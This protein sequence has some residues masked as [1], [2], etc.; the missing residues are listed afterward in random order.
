MSASRD[1]EIGHTCDVSVKSQL[2][3]AV[4]ENDRTRLRELIL[5]NHC[6]PRF[7]RN[8][9]KE[10]LLHI[11][12]KLG[13]LDIIRSLVEVYQLCPFQVDGFSLTPCHLA[14]QFHHLHVLGYFFKL[15]G[16]T[17]IRDFQPI[18]LATIFKLPDDFRLHLL[19]EATSSHSVVMTRFVYTCL[20]VKSN[21]IGKMNLYYDSFNMLMKIIAPELSFQHKDSY[22]KFAAFY[23]RDNLNMLKLFL[24]E[25]VKVSSMSRPMESS[26]CGLFLEAACRLNNSEIV[27]YLTKRKGLC[28]NQELP[29]QLI[30]DCALQPCIH[31]NCGE[32]PYLPMHTALLS[33]NITF[34]ESIVLTSTNFIQDVASHLTTDHGTLL[35]SACVS[36]KLDL[37]KIVTQKFKGDIN[38]QNK[39][40]NTPL[41]VAC[42]WGWLEIVQFLVEI[43][44]NVNISN[45]CG[46]S[47]LT[48]AIKHSRLEIFK[49]LFS[50]NNVSIDVTTTDTNESTLHLACCCHHSEFAVALLNDP[51]YTISLDAVDKFGDTPLFNACRL[52]NMKVVQKLVAKPGCTRLMVNDITKETPAHIAC[53]N[54]RLD[55]LKVLLTVGLSEPLKNSHLNF[56]GESL[57]HIA[58]YNDAQE[59]IDFL[60]ENQIITRVSDASNVSPIHIA[61]KRGN[62]ETVKKL[63]KSGICKTTD[64]DMN[65]NTILHYIC[66]R[67]Q[68]DPEMIEML[69]KEMEAN[70]MVE[71]KNA[72]GYNPLHLIFENGGGQIFHCLSNCLSLERINNALHSVDKENN[73]PLHVAFRQQRSLTLRYLLDNPQFADGIS[74]AICTQNTRKSSPLHCPC[75]TE[76]IQ[77][78]FESSH[79][80]YECISRAVAL[81]DE[82][83]NNIFHHLFNKVV[84]NPSLLEV[85]SSTFKRFLKQF[86]LTDVVSVLCM[87][88]TKNDYDFTFTP[89]QLLI[90]RNLSQR[91]CEE[92]SV[93]EILLCLVDSPLT[94]ESMRDICSI[95]F[96]EGK[97]LVHFAL[98]HGFF[99][100]VKVLVEHKLCDPE[101]ADIFGRTPL[102]CA[103]NTDINTNQDIAC[104][105]CR[106]GCS[107]HT[108]DK[109]G[110]S[111]VVLC[112][113]RGYYSVSLLRRLLSEGYCHP[114]ETV[115][116]VECDNQI[117]RYCHIMQP[118][119]YHQ[120]IIELPLLHSMLYSRSIH[121]FFLPYIA[122]HE[123]TPNLCDSFGNTIFH[124]ESSYSLF[125]Y[126]VVDL[127]NHDLNKQNKEGN[128]PLHIACATGQQN[129]GKKLIESDKCG[130]SL[131]LRNRYGHTPVYY[132]SDRELINVLVMNGA[133]P[134]DVADS[135][136]VKHLTDM[137][138]AV[139]DKHPLNLTVT[140]L[141][142][143]NSLAGK[144][145]LLKSLT[146]ACNSDQLNQ[147]SVGQLDEK[148]ERTA[149][150]EMSEYVVNIKE[151]SQRVLFYDFAG[152]PEFH[153]THS[154]LLQNRLSSLESSRDSPLLFVIVIDITAPDKLKQ[155]IYW[156]KF[157][158][159]CQLSCNTGRKPEILIIGSHVDKYSGSDDMHKKLKHSLC[160][161]IEK[162]SDSIDLVENPIFLNCCK[163]EENEL[164]K[165]Q[166]ML[167]MSTKKLE[168][169]A[170]L[171][172]RCHLIFSY[173]YDHFPDK[174]V[175]FSEFQGKLRKRKP[176]GNIDFHFTTTTLQDL[177]TRLHQMQHIL[178]IG[179]TIESC[180]FWI[181]TAKAQNLMFH[182][183]QGLLFSGEDFDMRPSI[184]SNVGVISSTEIKAMFPDF[185]CKMLQQFLVYSEFC[186]KIDD[187]TVLQLIDC[188]ASNSVDSKEEQKMN[189]SSHV[190]NIPDEVSVVTETCD[191][192]DYFFFPG[193]VKETREKTKL[194]WKVDDKYSFC[195]GWSLECTQDEFFNALFLQVLLLRLTFQFAATS[196]PD[197]I[198]H[199]RCVI[200]KNGVFWS[201]PGV[202]MLVE[203]TNQN[204]SVIVLVRC[205]KDTEL[206]AIKLR[207]AVL[208]E[209]FKVKAKHS[210]ATKVI[211]FVIYNPSLD[212]NG[213]L[214]E[215]VKKVAMNEIA[216]SITNCVKYVQDNS[217]QHH[218]INKDLLCFEPYTGI[219]N[220]TLTSLFDPDETGKNVPDNILSSLFN[221]PESDDQAKLT[222]QFKKL[223]KN[224]SKPIS[225][226]HLRNLFD[227][228]SIFHGRDPKV[229][230]V[231]I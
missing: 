159:N 9:K 134:K 64:T 186:K 150:I 174:P 69:S 102:H 29:P 128:T 212:E 173:L 142:L 61:C 81:Q 133:D 216:A 58:C 162:M 124:L 10:T 37:V 193:L 80:S 26:V 145:T 169:L 206:E 67:Q 217:F 104:F 103:C 68:I 76:Y 147:P 39:H 27:N 176:G 12:S 190:P 88:N 201:V 117:Q 83:G 202:E 146:N 19:R 229:S 225:Y 5:S 203:V 132:T 20:C 184:K 43:G 113:Q 120:S 40:G 208:K 32:L 89:L 3:S 66:H 77:L 34:V 127:R 59:T 86:R 35:H 91:R 170:D 107:A 92:S 182:E 60:I 179:P 148:C 211:E 194:N 199:R 99:K 87:R 200:W 73:T 65:G 28:P 122:E 153:S 42:E 158:Q 219:D 143:G 97:T 70:E 53:R 25:L 100:T 189:Q 96:Y 54:D 231:H 75:R 183:V 121:N 4:E 93:I 166:M 85:V 98:E 22:L 195:S 192:I 94:A 222:E 226:E 160:Q 197:S 84:E 224:L 220:N 109:N 125:Q 188:E 111:P 141:V 213:S 181:L 204:Q 154:I 49:S 116:T 137:F 23:C 223:I 30:E 112:L 138:K 33:G 151:R 2:F 152:H 1:S 123:N 196:L 156:V 110:K 47:P 11:A 44:C 8:E 48:L 164:Q 45:N 50:N 105:L 118:S 131:S 18:H 72:S 215:P 139:K 57:L 114:M 17:Y 149:G 24:D 175:K 106:N 136:R 155:L 178:L 41:H 172:N 21:G 161:T 157:I 144:T 218:C 31:Y 214:T 140:A 185:E 221:K 210:P 165:V 187:E 163:P 126:K 115:Q 191:S 108:L 46:H 63:L 101:T 230:T 119:E 52:G 228:Y 7:V 177:I 16:Y 205:F 38:I 130:K 13:L 6:D 129:M 78:L 71:K 171:D 135:A 227:E 209:V 198:L 15:G 95:T 74:K 14:C 79:L 36:G 56:L 207:S 55:L 82:M 51:R 62:V 90:F 180:D 168:K 167:I